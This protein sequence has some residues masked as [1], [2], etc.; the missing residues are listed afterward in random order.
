MAV[1]QPH[2]QA[3]GMPA[4]CR[5]L[6]RPMASCA[7]RAFHPASSRRSTV[8]TPKTSDA[9][10]PHAPRAITGAAHGPVMV[11]LESMNDEVA[12]VQQPFRVGNTGGPTDA[13]VEGERQSVS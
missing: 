10:G 12:A 9:D 5:R 3:D 7:G 8:T 4:A 13:G 2:R 6:R 11:V 1:D